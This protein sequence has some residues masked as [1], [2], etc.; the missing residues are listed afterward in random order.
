[1]LS[2][3][4]PPSGSSWVRDNEWLSDGYGPQ[5]ALR[6]PTPALPRE[7]GSRGE[8]KGPG[9]GGLVSCREG[10]FLVG[11]GTVH[12]GNRNVEQAETNPEL[13]AVVN[14]AVEDGAHDGKPA[15]E[16]D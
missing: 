2:N 4:V 15:V 1:M 5:M 8:A 14:Q 16:L 12:A 7:G 13:G 11:R 10:I 3:G 9:S 6:S